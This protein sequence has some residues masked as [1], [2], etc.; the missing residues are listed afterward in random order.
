MENECKGKF[1]GDI[2]LITNLTN[3]KCYVG[4]T[5][6]GIKRRF[7]QHVITAQWDGISQ[8]IVLYKAIRKYGKDNFTVG[9]LEHVEC[10][11]K[12]ELRN[13]LNEL[14]VYYISK[15]NTLIPNGYNMTIGGDATD[16]VTKIPVFEVDKDGNVI[17]YFNSCADA[18]REYNM[19]SGKVWCGTKNKNHYSCGHYWYRADEF[20]FKI[21][22]NIGKQHNASKPV[23]Q[24]DLDCNFLKLFDSITEASK[25]TGVC[26]GGIRC[27]LKNYHG[28]R[29]SGGYLWSYT[30]IPPEYDKNLNYNSL[31]HC[32]AIIQLTTTGEFVKEFGSTVEAGKAFNICS[33]SIY[34]CLV[35]KSKT[36]AGYKWVYAKDYYN[37]EVVSDE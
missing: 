19:P 23:Y 7:N 33:S 20:N 3:E 8:S 6:V 30:D 16:E 1:S 12:E 24:F 31:S 2:Y 27:V 37:K 22:D 11:T 29:Q 35:G 18:D 34:Q 10:N 36:C 4:Q 15:N 14:E 5:I 32:K 26:V 21:G 9:L 28:C 13:K 25:E 17:K